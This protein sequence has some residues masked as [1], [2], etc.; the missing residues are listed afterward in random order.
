M[1]N[2]NNVN[3]L[4]TPIYKRWWFWTLAVAVI[5]AIAITVVNSLAG[6]G[7]TVVEE[8]LY[9]VNSSSYTY[10]ALAL[11]VKNDSS[12]TKKVQV[13]VNFY[14]DGELL[15]SGES[16]LVV[17]AP[18]DTTTLRAVCDHGYLRVFEKTYTYKITKWW[19]YDV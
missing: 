1:D 11:D 8:R 2:Q 5:I 6:N 9:N 16:S 13:E 19:V 15:G 14:A 3:T 4:K 12:S 10:P 18:G 7:I 17:L